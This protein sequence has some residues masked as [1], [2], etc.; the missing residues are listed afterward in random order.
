MDRAALVPVTAL[1]DR[2]KDAGGAAATGSMALPPPTPTNPPPPLWAAR[3]WRAA[4]WRRHG[5]QFVLHLHHLPGAGV[6]WQQALG[7]VF[8]NAASSAALVTGVRERIIGAIPYSLKLAITCGIGLSSHS[9]AAN[10]GVIVA[11][12]RR[13]HPRRFHLGPRGAVP[14]GPRHHTV[15]VARRLPG[16][17]CSA[18]RSRRSSDSWFQRRRWHGH[19]WPGSIVSAPPRRAAVPAA[20]SELP[21]T[22]RPSSRRCRSS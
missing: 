1:T 11:S 19:A 6:P 12:P 16:A 17:S 7:M 13:R 5:H 22:D 20:R 10:G 2:S 15:L 3:G 18:S 21:T 14:R 9:W 8:V 4:G